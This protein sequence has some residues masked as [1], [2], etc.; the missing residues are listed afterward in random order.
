MMPMTR[1][2]AALLTAL[3]LAGCSSAPPKAAAVR[4]AAHTCADLNLP[5]QT[6]GH[7]LVDATRAAELDDRWDDL[8]RAL[9]DLR[10]IQMHP[11]SPSVVRDVSRRVDRECR[12]ARTAAG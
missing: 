2:V 12:R 1:L 9:S 11:Q 5:G 10:D 8:Y 3:A 7:I 6:W 4:A